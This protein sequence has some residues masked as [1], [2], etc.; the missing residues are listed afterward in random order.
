MH[1]YVGRPHSEVCAVRQGALSYFLMRPQNLLAKI[2]PDRFVLVLLA[3]VALATTLPVQGS[4]AP[5]ASGI[6]TGA[7]VMLFFLHGLRLPRK[8]VLAALTHWRLNGAAFL[9]CFA[10]MPLAGWITAHGF[11]AAL[12]PLITAGLIYLSVMPSTV[13]S[14]TTASSM[15]GGNVA[16]SVIMAALLNLAG[17]VIS[18]LLFALLGAGQSGFALSADMV[19]RIMGMLL[20]PFA[21]GQILQ[22][23]LQSWAQRNRIWTVQL[24]RTAI[25]IAVYV[26]LSGAVVAGLWRSLSATDAFYL[27]IALSILLVSSFG[28]AWMLG[29]AAALPRPDAISLLFAGAQKSVAVGAPMAA[30]L[31]TPAT[32]G[33]ILLPLIAFHIAQLI[34]SA[35]FAAH[36]RQQTGILAT[37]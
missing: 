12:P 29:K 24:D 26:A 23:W 32:A 5:F 1:P 8:D 11:A 35:W 9:F 31:F 27:A 30:I 22:R 34:L 16:A 6:A 13:Q 2:F 4:A 10:A 15:A 33:A 19:L 3:M 25:A 18:P 21:L 37:N 7:V 17:M 20:L 36:L 28:G 14:A